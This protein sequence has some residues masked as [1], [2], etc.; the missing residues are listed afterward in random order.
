VTAPGALPRTIAAPLVVQ[1]LRTNG[2]DA[3]AAHKRLA[4][5]RINGTVQYYRG[6][7]RIT[8]TRV[9]LNHSIAVRAMEPFAR[10]GQR[11]RALRVSRLLVEA[12]NRTAAL[13]I[14]DAQRA[15]TRVEEQIDAPGQVRSAEQQLENARR[16]YDRAQSLRERTGD[17]R[18]TIQQRARALHQYAIA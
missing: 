11:D 3:L 9:F 18:R 5:A 1:R 12:D 7:T 2:S 17:A 15:L 14:Q 8:D 6:R 13:A 16:A 4:S 10:A